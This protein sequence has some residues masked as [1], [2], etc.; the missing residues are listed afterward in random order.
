VEGEAAPAAATATGEGR[1]ITTKE[2]MA[3]AAT[4]IM[5]AAT[6]ATGTASTC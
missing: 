4:I 6:N 3:S 1:G 5:A 2:A